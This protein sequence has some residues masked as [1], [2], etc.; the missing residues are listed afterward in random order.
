MTTAAYPVP[1]MSWMCIDCK[2]KF[3]GP[4]DA[5]PPGGC[6]ACGSANCFDIN[7]A[8]VRLAKAVR[9]LPPAGSARLAARLYDAANNR[10]LTAREAR[11]LLRESA[12][13]IQRLQQLPLL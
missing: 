11:K 12:D 1:S 7:V 6:P 3:E 4:T 8:P 9:T 5:P 2:T 13:E 10:K